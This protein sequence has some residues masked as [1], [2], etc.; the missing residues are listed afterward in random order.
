M[1]LFVNR[2][3][4]WPSPSQMVAE[5]T[6]A[7]G[8]GRGRVS[9]EQL[10][11]HSVAWAA[12]RLRADLIS[13]MPVDVFRKVR[14][15]GRDVQVEVPKPGIFVK[16]GGE[17]VSW[18]EWM[19]ATQ[20]DLDTYGNTFGIIT[21]IDG[22]GLPAEI[23]LV[24]AGT[25]TVC[26]KDGVRFYRI[27]GK[28]YEDREIWHERQF[29]VAGLPVGL[30][31]IAYS[32]MSVLGYLDAQQ[33]AR[34]WFSNSTIPSGHLKNT[35][36]TLNRKESLKAKASF[37]AA[38]SSGDVWVSG[39]DWEYDMLAA[40]ASESGFIEERQLSDREV[41]R[42]YGVPADMVDVDTATGTVTYANITQRNLQL[43]ILNIGPAV[44]RRETAFSLNLLPQP[45]YA[46]LNANALLRMDVKSRYEGYKIAIDARFMPPSE[47]RAIEDLPPM[48]P[49]QEAE[50]ARLFPAKAA[51][52]NPQG[53]TS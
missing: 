51:T 18:Q 47:V 13:T 10:L 2:A 11:G 45:R 39:N 14:V 50:F 19:Y 24:A 1:S 53:V 41:C 21:K 52:P 8:N 48:T 17:R 33:F 32:A 15:D 43:L 26:S 23:E 29:V 28:R 30:S 37:K 42:F 9:R 34:D 22:A 3:G 46:K 36:K 5:R 7:R 25:V 49:E 20:V 27:N 38:V 35:A 12:L 6:A 31:P 16:P 40:K 4:G 44:Y